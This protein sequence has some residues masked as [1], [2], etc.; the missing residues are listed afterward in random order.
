MYR[1]LLNYCH[2][3]TIFCSNAAF[4]Q[5]C[6]TFYFIFLNPKITIGI[7]HSVFE[8]KV[9]FNVLN[10]SKNHPGCS[11]MIGEAENHLLLASW[12]HLGRLIP[13]I[14]VLNKQIDYFITTSLNACIVSSL[15]IF[16]WRIDLTIN[17]KVGDCQ[18]L[19]LACV[20]CIISVWHLIYWTKKWWN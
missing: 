2:S 10:I 16:P 4:S 11:L 20:T 5:K 12:V 9:H 3:I 6:F 13:I 18:L 17:H 15:A 8:T 1:Q 14:A 19:A 7:C